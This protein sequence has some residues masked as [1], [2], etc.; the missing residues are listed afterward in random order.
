MRV[1]SAV[2]ENGKR[3]DK[4]YTCDGE[5]V[6]PPVSWDPVSGAASYA[7]ILE[8]PDAPMGTFVHWVIYNI[9]GT[10]LKE[11]DGSSTSQAGV[12]GRNDFGRIGYGGPCPPRGHGT[13]RYFFRVYALKEDLPVKKGVTASE[14]RRM[15]Q[16][17]VV[18]QGEIYATYSRS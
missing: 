17:K 15:M 10:S 12:Q 2:F 7:L 11:G 13:H 6:S 14:L 1:Y 4:K 9:K 8:D 18:D 3:I 16:G 5:D